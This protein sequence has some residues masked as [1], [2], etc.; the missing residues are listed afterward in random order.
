MISILVIRFKRENPTKMQPCKD[1]SRSARGP[2]IY[3]KVKANLYS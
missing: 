2:F 3:T 1:S